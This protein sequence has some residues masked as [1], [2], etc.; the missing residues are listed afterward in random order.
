MERK[1]VPFIDENIVSADPLVQTNVTL[2]PHAFN[3]LNT[4]DGDNFD[5]EGSVKDTFDQCKDSLAS[6]G[7]CGGS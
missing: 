1:N 2:D 6:S 7:G 4:Y 5:T 3:A